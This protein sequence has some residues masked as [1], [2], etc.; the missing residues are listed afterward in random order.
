MIRKLEHISYE[1]S[2]RQLGLFNLGK[3][4]L[5]GDLIVVFQYVKSVCKEDRDR[6]F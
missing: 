2:S 6:L 5:Q 4:R 3:S 1:K